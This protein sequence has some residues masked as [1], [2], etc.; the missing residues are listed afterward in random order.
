[1]S[2]VLSFVAMFLLAAAAAGQGTPTQAPDHWKAVEQA[3]GRAGQA[4]PG[5]VFKFSLPRR[6]LHVAVNGIEVKPGFGLGS[7]VAFKDA[8]P[9][10][11][12]MGD[13]VLTEPEVEPV[14][15]RLL[16]SGIEVTALH[17]H[18]LGE[19]PRVMYMHLAGHGD[20]ATLARA[21]HDALKLTATPAAEPAAAASTSPGLEQGRIEA[22]LGRSGKVNGGILQFSVPRNETVTMHAQVVPPSMGVATAV[23]FE[24]AGNGQA[25][26]TGDF[27][28]LGSEVN[29]VLAALRKNGIDV[30]AVH[31]H[32]LEEAPRLFFVH[33]WASGDAVRLAQGVRAALERTNSAKAASK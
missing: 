8:G 9:Q 17:N 22:A 3:L 10:A 1:M 13:L 30:A 31:S 4:Q 28:L 32:M 15:A 16:E 19:S 24:P 12:V 7:W 2:P 23:N 14:M 18:L 26:I 20:A 21:I 6:D 11:M 29:P 25:A 5:G 33:F 27:V